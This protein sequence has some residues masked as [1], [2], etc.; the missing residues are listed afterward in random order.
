MNTTLVTALYDIGRSDWGPLFT[1]PMETYLRYLENI[2]SL[3]TNIVIFIDSTYYDYILKIRSRIDPDL[4]KT[5][6]ILKTFEELDT[7]KQFYYKTKEV[8][9]S[10]F[11][12]N[13]LIEPHV[14]E[15]LY[16]KYN[17]INFNKVSFI[18][19]V[20]DKNYF[21]SDYFM[22]ID[23]GFWHEN[24]P[25]E[26]LN[27]IYPNEEK[28]KVLDDNKVHFLSL[29]K[30]EDVVLS[31][32]FD[33]RVSIAGSM[34]AGKAEPLLKFKKLCYFVIEQFLNKGAINDDQTIYAFAYKKNKE[35]FNLKQGNW[36]D[37][38][39]FYI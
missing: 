34:F 8:M 32:C 3:D 29:C 30:D 18:E 23:A 13:H 6:I 35:L 21:N 37:N 27:N 22:W 12:K 39:K 31:S 16:P 1:R 36:F 11:F 5:R 38:F 19:E 14:P 15:A 10:D 17:I 26:Y 2:L 20:I 25:K 28:I 24:F 7:Y 33:P 9:N 4:T